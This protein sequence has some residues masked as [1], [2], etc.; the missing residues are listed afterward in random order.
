MADPI[1]GP[2]L[3][4]DPLEAKE[5]ERPFLALYGLYFNDAPSSSFSESPKG[6]AT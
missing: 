4:A 2:P 1:L 5:S 3:I 6:F